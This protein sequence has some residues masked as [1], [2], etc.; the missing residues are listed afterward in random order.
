MRGR[1]DYRELVTE[2]TD[3]VA[4]RLMGLEVYEIPDILTRLDYDP[5]IL[6]QP[7]I[8]KFVDHHWLDIEHLEL[9]LLK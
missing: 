7:N 5:G 1:E 6:L 9:Y 4:Q 8:K 3:E 2:S